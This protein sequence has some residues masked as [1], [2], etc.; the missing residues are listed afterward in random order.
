M[1]ER[2]DE[3]ARKLDECRKK[4]NK[5]SLEW[6]LESARILREAKAEARRGFGKWLQEQARMDRDTAYR[7]LRV[8]EFVNR[9]A[10]LN[11]HFANL[12]I[13]KIYSISRLDSETARGV[14]EGGDPFSKPIEKLTDVEFHLEFRQKYPSPKKR[15]SRHNARTSLESAM[16]RLER[17]IKRVAPLDPM[18]ARKMME[19][20]QELG[21][22]LAGWKVVA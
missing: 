4:G 14:I 3:L 9:N 21:Q 8:S 12:S 20:W 19:K 18:L 1:S 6:V 5:L 15:R 10:D 22:I 11:R 13:A 7:H 2:L 16:A 17:A